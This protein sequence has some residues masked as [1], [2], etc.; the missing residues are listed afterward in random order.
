MDVV[1]LTCQARSVCESEE[2]GNCRN[3]ER[4]CP[5]GKSLYSDRLPSINES[6]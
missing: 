2:A 6:R 3:N 1:R 4:R 5:E